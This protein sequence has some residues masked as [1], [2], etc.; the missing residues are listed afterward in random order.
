MNLVFFS[1]DRWGVNVLLIKP[2]DCTI[3][4]GLDDSEVG[5]CQ[6][7]TTASLKPE[8]LPDALREG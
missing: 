1:R 5:G 4:P 7:L 6:A 3:G 8:L 2:M